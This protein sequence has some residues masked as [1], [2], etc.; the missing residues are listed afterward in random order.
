MQP[1]EKVNKRNKQFYSV[2]FSAVIQPSQSSHCET[3]GGA[4]W[5]S[6]TI[7]PEVLW[8][9]TNKGNVGDRVFHIHTYQGELVI[10]QNSLFSLLYGFLWHLGIAVIRDA[11]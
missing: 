1:C 6:E 3:G 2:F 9:L 10:Q 11:G 8:V 5:A 4:Q 7:L